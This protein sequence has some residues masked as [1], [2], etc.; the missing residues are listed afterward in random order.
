MSVMGGVSR[1]RSLS[2]C[3]TW[4][5]RVSG[6]VE[7]TVL[8]QIQGHTNTRTSVTDALQKEYVIDYSMEFTKDWSVSSHHHL[9]GKAESESERP[10]NVESSFRHLVLKSKTPKKHLQSYLNST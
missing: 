6:R 5:L 4:M 10:I 7:I 9:K 2:C 1:N 3:L 8:V